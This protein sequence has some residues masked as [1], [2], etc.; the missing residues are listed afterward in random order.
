MESP[1]RIGIIDYRERG[2]LAEYEEAKK[3]RLK[4]TDDSCRKLADGEKSNL[5]PREK[6][7]KRFQVW[8]RESFVR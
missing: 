3:G 4:E 2:L 7:R 6:K 8:P 5:F 1:L